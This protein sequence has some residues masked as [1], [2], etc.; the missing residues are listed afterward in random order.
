MEVLGMNLVAA[1]I[2]KS[3]LEIENRCTDCPCFDL[4]AASIRKF[5]LEIRNRCTKVPE[6]SPMD[7]AIAKSGPE[8]GN[9]CMEIPETSLLAAAIVKSR[10]EIGN[11]SSAIVSA[12]RMARLQQ[13]LPLRCRVRFYFSSPQSRTVP[14][15]SVVAAT[16]PCLILIF[17]RLK[18]EWFRLQLPLRQR[19]TVSLHRMSPH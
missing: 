12:S 18:E 4:F 9:H 10:P 14:P 19:R 17:C 2:A 11:H 7:A 1:A 8:I 3:G 6:M 15:T 13:V 5:G 16:M